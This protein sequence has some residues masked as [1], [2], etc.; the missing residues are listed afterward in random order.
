MSGC[1]K[2]AALAISCGQLLSGCLFAPAKYG[3]SGIVVP[4]DSQY[5]MYLQNCRERYSLL[6][7]CCR[8]WGDPAGIQIGNSGG[9][10]VWKDSPRWVKA[11]TFGASVIYGRHPKLLMHLVFGSR[12]PAAVKVPA[13][14]VFSSYSVERFERI[15][16]NEFAYAFRLRLK[17][18]ADAGLSAMD[19]VKRELRATI[20]E[21]YVAAHG[22]RTADVQVDFPVFTLKDAVIEGRAEVMRIEVASLRYDPQAQKGV[23]AVKIGSNRFEDA[24]LWVRK[25]I[26]TLAKDKNVA[27]TTGKIPPA[28]RFYLGAERVRDG[29]ILEIEFETE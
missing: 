5:A 22:G 20:A 4:G 3:S 16:D 19:R 27:L 29:N 12:Q 1:V 11:K 26:E 18:G 25:N 23:I 10:F 6:D 15:S 13:A 17:D 21:D 9:Y 14:S 2:V 7:E 24:R 28:A 8:N